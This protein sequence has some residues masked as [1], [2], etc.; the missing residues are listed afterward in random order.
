MPKK[1]VLESRSTGGRQLKQTGKRSTA[2]SPNRTQVEEV[3]VARRP[4]PGLSNSVQLTIPGR[5]GRVSS[6]DSYALKHRVIK[7]SVGTTSV[8]RA[9]IAA[10]ARDAVRS[11]RSSK[12]QVG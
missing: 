12:H 9:K 7:D 2:A 3:S 11:R 8:S 4:I 10:A 6:E 1:T 5:H